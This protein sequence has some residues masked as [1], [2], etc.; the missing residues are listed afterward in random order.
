MGVVFVSKLNHGPPSVKVDDRELKEVD[1][2]IKYLGSVLTRDGYC[3][4]EIKTRIGMAK[5]AFNRKISLLTSKLNT[6]LRKKLVRCYVWST[7]LYDSVTWTLRKLKQKYLD[8]FVMWCWR[9]MEKIK[10]S[11]NLTNLEHIGEKRKLL[12]YPT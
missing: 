2:F 3:T 12:Q 4:R 11:E 5:E 8:S 1:H 6:E 10:Q 9:R 7:A